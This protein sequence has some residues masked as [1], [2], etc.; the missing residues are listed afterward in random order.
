MPYENLSGKLFKKNNNNINLC[1]IFFIKKKLLIHIL[2][3]EYFKK[4]PLN[5]LMHVFVRIRLKITESNRN[6]L[7]SH[8][9]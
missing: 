7:E 8:S 1:L 4:L 6:L 3:V 2:K 9:F 5:W